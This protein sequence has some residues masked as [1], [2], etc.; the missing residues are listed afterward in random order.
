MQQAAFGT[1]RGLLGR[2]SAGLSRETEAREYQVERRVEALGGLLPGDEVPGLRRS[3]D[4][5]RLPPAVPPEA[6][7]RGD[8]RNAYP[9][10]FQQVLP[11]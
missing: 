5:D 8:P 4:P 1:V 10:N 7:T 6:L 2:S 3:I 9:C 11:Q